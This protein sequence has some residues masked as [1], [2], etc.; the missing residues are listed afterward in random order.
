[1]ITVFEESPGIFLAEVS[2]QDE[3]VV[4]GARSSCPLEAVHKVLSMALLEVDE[5]KE[6]D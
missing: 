5:D 4:W 2:D 1:M 6:F 3:I